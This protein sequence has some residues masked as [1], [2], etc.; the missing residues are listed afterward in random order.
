[1][2]NYYAHRRFGAQV[3]AALPPALAAVLERER[4]AFDLGLYG[5]DPLFFYRPLLHSRAHV[6]GTSMHHQPVRP[7]AQ[8][9]RQAVEDN[10]PFSRGYAAGFLCHFALD[11]R[12]HAY[13]NDRNGHGVTH[14]GMESELDRAL[15]LEDGIDPLRATPLPRPALPAEAYETIVSAAYPGVTADQFRKGFSGFFRVSRLLTR[16]SGTCLRQVVNGIARIPLCAFFR[17]AV[18]TPQPNPA[19][20]SDT[21]V[22]L[23]LLQ[24]EVSPTAQAVAGFFTAIAKGAPLTSSWYDRDFEG[25]CF[26][27]CP[28]FRA[29]GGP[30][31]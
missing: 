31:L 16:A 11:F 26:P 13:I 1:M 5:P 3:L 12:C 2:P 28:A 15:M 23:D 7:V 29:A 25:N 20:A 10:R 19:Y 18:L 9:L 24:R 17:E 4:E 22:L 27:A 21:A 6:L 30:A 8:R 14:S